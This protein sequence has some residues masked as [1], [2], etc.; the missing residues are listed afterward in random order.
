MTLFLALSLICVII[1]VSV[2]YISGKKEKDFFDFMLEQSFNAKNELKGYLLEEDAADKTAYQAQLILY[3]YICCDTALGDCTKK[4]AKKLA[5]LYMF[6][7]QQH[8][9]TFPHKEQNTIRAYIEQHGMTT[10]CNYQKIFM[11]SAKS[12]WTLLDSLGRTVYAQIIKNNT[13]GKYENL[14]GEQELSFC[15]IGEICTDTIKGIRS[16]LP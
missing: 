12:K 2:A 14:Q 3:A 16:C 7:V 13:S 4:Q 15:D 5:A 9:I 8:L 6:V 11:G 10:L 1:A